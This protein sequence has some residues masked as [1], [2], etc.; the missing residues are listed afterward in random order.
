MAYWT[1]GFSKEE[2]EHCTR[3]PRIN[4][5]WSL[6]LLLLNMNQNEMKVLCILCIFYDIKLV[7]CWNLLLYIYSINVKTEVNVIQKMQRRLCFRRKDSYIIKNIWKIE[8]RTILFLVLKATCC[9]QMHVSTCKLN[10]LTQNR[11]IA[12]FMYLANDAIDSQT[13]LHGYLFFSF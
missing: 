5:P 4:S 8:A 12:H 1:L 2:Q 3:L 6:V 7:C 9:Y 13:L 10:S 11:R